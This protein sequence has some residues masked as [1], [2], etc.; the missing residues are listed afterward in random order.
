MVIKGSKTVLV[1]ED[2]EYNYYLAEEILSFRDI[3]VL[4]AWNG[5]EAVNMVKDNPEIDLVIMDIKMPV[6]GGLEATRLIKAYK[7][8][9]PVI[10]LTAYA[11]EGDRQLAIKNGCDDYLPKP[12]SIKILENMVIKYLT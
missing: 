3:K 4:H 11:L 2:E 1:V 12:V 5:E 10:A 9:L 8:D 7:P 6:M